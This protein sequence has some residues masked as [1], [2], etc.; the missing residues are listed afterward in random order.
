MIRKTKLVYRVAKRA[1]KRAVRGQLSYNGHGPL[2]MGYK[3]G[4]YFVRNGPKAFV[5]RTKQTLV[6]IDRRLGNNLVFPNGL[7]SGVDPLAIQHWYAA[8]AKPVT[9]VI[10]SYND[11]NVLIPCLESIAVTTDPVLVKIIVVDDYCVPEHQVEIKKLEND[12]VTVILREANGGFAKAVNTGLR[13]ADPKYDVVL[14]N[15]DI[16]AHSNWIEGLQFGAY[17]FGVDV[18]LVAPKLLYPDGKIQSAGSHRN[19]ESPQWFDHYYRFQDANYGPANVPQY[20]LGVT[21]ACIYAKREFLDYVGLLDEG[22]QFAFEDMDWCIRGWEAG[23]RSLYFPAAT[24]THHE[25]VTRAKNKDISPKE[26]QAI[27]FFWDKWGDWFDKR[28]VLDKDGKIRVIFVLQTFGWSGGIK[29]VFEQANFLA[30]RGLSIEIWGIDEQAPVWPVNDKVKIRTFKNYERL[31][32]ALSPQEAI[33]VATW[34]ETSFPVWL[35][36]VRK[37]RPVN[38]VQEFETWFYPNDVV[39]QAMVVACYRKEFQNLT[40]SSYN[41][42]ELQAIGLTATLLPCGYEGTLYRPLSGVKRETNT[43]LTVGRSFFQ[44]NLDMT[45]KAWKLLGESRPDMWMFGGEPELARHDKKITYYKKPSNEEVNELYNKATIFI[46]TSR[47]EGFCLPLLEA[48]AAGCPVICT[49]AHGNRDF[50]FK[51]KNCLM[52]EQDDAE[53]LKQAIEKLM[54]SPALRKKLSDEALKT[55]K[56]FRWPVIMDQ[57]EAFYRKVA[58]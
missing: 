16:V 49:D 55:V 31:I 46:Q 51:D 18:G 1:A 53:G 17:E 28:N 23:Y 26:K 44:K 35:S 2:K 10:P 38:F 34:W 43:I 47:H 24:L 42:E 48:M 19:T 58:K 50:C 11:L 22:F 21:G 15:S 14:V 6:K 9:V 5:T 56:D 32:G 7:V 54:S 3:A 40:I 33:K 41:L 27:K 39:A 57:S 52:V 12:Q 4:K 8:K 45:L 30:E 37:G 20:C 25:G 29:N 13:A 36:S